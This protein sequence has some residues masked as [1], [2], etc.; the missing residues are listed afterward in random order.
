VKGRMKA[1][2]VFVVLQFGH[3]SSIRDGEAT[4]S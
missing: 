3:C 1:L 4:P 2:V